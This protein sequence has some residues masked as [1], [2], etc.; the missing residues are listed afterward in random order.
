M[1]TPLNFYRSGRYNRTVFREGRYLLNTEAMEL[2]LETLSNI[3]DQIAKVF[4]PYS[5]IGKA[6]KV[7]IDPNDSNRII[8][9]PG[10]F[11]LDS[12]SL[13]IQ[14]GTDHLV[15]LGTSP[16]EITST[17]FVSIENDGT[18]IGGFAINFGAPTATLSNTYSIVVSVEEELITPSSDPYLRSANLNEDT[19]DKHRIILNINVIESS[20]LDAS[21]IPYVGSDQGNLVNEIEVSR[22]VSNYGIV[23]TNPITGSEAIDGANL[24]IVINNGNG[25]T[26]AALPVSNT[27]LDEYIQGKMIDSNGVS[28]HIT[29]MFVTPGNSSTVTM[30]LDLEK[31]RPV[32]AA[33][34]QAT[35]VLNI[36]IPY[37]LVK[38]DLYVTSAS[39]LPTGKRFWEVSQVAW[40]GASFTSITDLRYNVLAR[41]GVLSQIRESGLNILS[42]GEFGWDST[43]NG[44]TL[45]WVDSIEFHSTFD[46]F[47]WTIGAS[48]TFSLFASGLATNEILYINLDDKPEGGSISLKKGLRGIGEL[49]LQGQ[50]AHRIVWLAKRL[51]D[52]RLYFYN[53]MVLND[54][55]VG[56]IYD[57]I[58]EEKLPE[59][60]STMGYKAMFLDEFADESVVN[61]GS[62]TGLY[63]AESYTL[64][65]NNRIITVSGNTIS[66]ASAP[67]FTVQVGDVIVQNGKYELITV[68][69]SA[70]SFDVADGS[71][72]TDATNGTLSQTMETNDLRATG[73]DAKSKIETYFSSNVDDAL[74]VYDD[75]VIPISGNAIKLGHSLTSDGADYGDVASRQQ[76]I[77]SIETITVAPTAGTDV[78]LRFFAIDTASDGSAT[79]ESFR[80]Y[81][82]KR[83]FVG[84]LL[85]AVA[86]TTN[87]GGG[88]SGE[89][90]QPPSEGL[91]NNTGGDL[92]SGRAVAVDPSGVIY[93]DATLVNTAI[94]L[95]GIL[96][97]P[98]VDGTDATDIVSGGYAPGVI[99]GLGFSAGD[100]VYLGT[101][102]Q[103]IDKV[104]ALA[105][106]LGSAIKEVGIAY[107]TTD[108]W[109]QIGN[110]EIV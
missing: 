17:D 100:E 54:K 69:N 36:S 49:S 93:A 7:E 57:P 40:D 99:T 65:Y 51:S 110:T 14:S 82:H 67:S 102:G 59:D 90:I 33:T 30:R 50:N 79:L 91:P 47:S 41:D 76:S 9:R 103:L 109:V 55:S 2:Q 58:V 8:V 108:L 70:S 75:G 10:E 26:T 56:T 80:T 20:K 96:T 86:T 105:L 39:Q 53:G 46:S 45:T 83:A 24:E 92:V 25:T 52:D 77:N 71:V 18:D 42:D 3:R 34:N 16:A 62:S 23:T 13:K 31:T 37:K 60:V 27:D 5:A 106:P 101:S 1:S 73:D 43:S 89:T 63:F 88:G 85:A 11:F 68:I 22:T 94:S 61:A 21:P 87:I 32:S 98:L 74:V 19:A 95:I 6:V 35:P 48:D 28:F 84:T 4:G 107:N 66:V 104:A 72:F 44:G 78:R 97:A 38:K 12:Y 81:M 64:Q 29:N 15:N